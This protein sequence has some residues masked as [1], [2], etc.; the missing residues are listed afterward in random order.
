MTKI[1]AYPE[2]SEAT[3]E[4]LLIGTDVETQKQTKNFSVK[5]IVDLI[6][7]PYLYQWIKSDQSLS[8][9]QRKGDVL[10]GILDQYTGEELTLSKVTG[11]PIVDNI[12]YFQLGSEYF[13]RNSNEIYLPA[14]SGDNQIQIQRTIDALHAS[15]GGIV[16][17]STGNYTINS[18]I[19]LKDGVS[20]KGVAPKF[21][22]NANCPDLNFTL[23]GGT[24][25][26][27]MSAG[28]KGLVA[29]E[30]DSVGVDS[31]LKAL[32]NVFIEDLGLKGFE[33]AIKVGAH[34]QLGFGMGG[35][36]RV[37]IDGT[38][39]DNATVVTK[40]AIELYNSQQMSS[41]MVLMYNVRNGLLIANN[42]ELVTCSS[43]NSVWGK[44]YIY[45]DPK[46]TSEKSTS[47]STITVGASTTITTTTANELSVNDLV[48]LVGVTG[49][50]GDIL[51]RVHA[52]SEIV[53]ETQFKV[54]TNTTGKII[55]ATGTC[56]K[57][58][59][60][61]HLKAEGNEPLNHVTFYSPQVN[62]F[63][64][65]S[66]PNKAIVNIALT[67]TTTS[68]VGAIGLYHTDT[69]GVTDHHL[70]IDGGSNITHKIGTM[71]DAPP[72]G[73]IAVY[74][75]D[76]CSW[77]SNDI[78]VYLKLGDTRIN[79]GN[80]ALKYSGGYRDFRPYSDFPSFGIID[81]IVNSKS[82][83][84]ANPQFKALEINN[85]NYTVGTPI[86]ANDSWM[87]LRLMAKRATTKITGSTDLGGDRLGYL[88]CENSSN[89]TITLPK[90]GTG[91]LEIPVGVPVTLNKVANDGTVNIVGFT[92]QTVGGKTVAEGGYLLSSLIGSSVTLMASGF[93][94][95]VV[96]GSNK[97]NNNG[98]IIIVDLAGTKFTNLNTAK[99]YVQSYTSAIL[100]EQS[101]SNGVYRF[102]VPQNTA[103]T[104]G[105]SFLHNSACSF[106]DN[107][108]LVTS[109]GQGAFY[110]N[111]GNSTFGNATFGDDSFT[112]TTGNYLFGNCTFGNY[113]FYQCSGIYSFG[114]VLST[115]GLF[116]YQSNG[117]FTI[118]GN[119]GPTNASNYT[120]F[121][122]E[123][124]S[125]IYA[126]KAKLTSNA[127]A[128]EGDLLTALNYGCSLFFGG[129]KYNPIFNGV[130]G[131]ST[132]PTTSAGT[133]DI[134]TR[135][136]STG[137]VEKITKNTIDRLTGYTVATL[138]AGVLGDTAYVT[139]ATTPTYLGT[140]V[141]S[142]SIKC[143]VFHNGTVWVSN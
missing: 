14:I 105:T 49:A 10:Y 32:S 66:Y 58:R 117:V 139:D 41:D 113:N 87:P 60:G 31:G 36:N 86:N 27:A 143:P 25:I 127:G 63:L 125:I 74:N 2:V 18:S 55:I 47:I 35:L 81:D 97:D 136:T 21:N 109:F 91:F 51:N 116:G 133:Y 100:S 54:Q 29:N 33:I 7:F 103:F 11:T 101:Y 42:K 38:G 121:F 104:V 69:E 130:V 98:K 56:E 88:Q 83:L 138:P 72:L 67:G 1:S 22:F 37:F 62:A 70:Y 140:L 123:S 48:Q 137:V 96:I 76:Q 128:I 124:T 75:S 40:K 102:T 53:S 135:N 8:L 129:E 6:E 95:W 79:D 94:D 5:S 9:A 30:I 106:I 131:I 65:T 43:G 34:N 50:D 71:I 84:C 57:G 20:I 64:N 99:N 107:L 59:A 120:D 17:L 46:T 110:N 12:I 134:L 141:G 78:D 77:E 3:I 82:Y 114:N 126:K 80:N 111:T 112:L 45:L 13:K 90:I 132:A 28:M 92:G 23:N 142:G 89:I 93:S 73:H 118:N 19:R 15:D 108:G 61:I 26:V 4:D 24:R 115:T 52:V 16:R 68:K 44:V 122:L 85:F 119:I 39:A